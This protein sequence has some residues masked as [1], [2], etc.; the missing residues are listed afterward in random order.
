M[1]SVNEA[2]S[3]T[4]IDHAAMANGEPANRDHR[5]PPGVRPS[6]PAKC[7][8]AA[9]SNVTAVKPSSTVVNPIRHS[10]NWFAN[11]T[12]KLD[13]YHQPLTLAN[14]RAVMNSTT[15]ANTARLRR[16]LSTWGVTAIA[17]SAPRE[18]AR[19]ANTPKWWVHLVGVNIIAKN[20]MTVIPMI[21]LLGPAAVPGIWPRRNTMATDTAS[22]ITRA[23][24][25]NRRAIDPSGVA[26]NRRSY[27][28]CSS[29]QLRLGPTARL[30]AFA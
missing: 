7:S 18:P 9:V 19:P 28:R 10:G 15:A 26:M 12:P 2:T 27:L 25:A 13:T 30:R 17:A 3:R 24:T 29:N 5:R 14:D 6:R 8:Q 16:D 21:R 23:N 1:P 20:E 11:G 22:A 4:T